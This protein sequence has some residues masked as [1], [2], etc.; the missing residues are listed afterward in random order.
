[1]I[2]D[3]SAQDRPLHAPRRRLP[4]RWLL[5]AGAVLA[6][7]A[8]TGVVARGW[9][10]GTGSVDGSRI[11]IAPVVRGTL[12]RDVSAEGR[13]TAS[14]SPTLYAVAGGT[15]DLKVIAGDRVERGQVLAVIDS[16]ELRS[17]LAQEQATAAALEA[18]VGRAALQVRQGSAEARKLVDQATIDHQ[19]AVREL[20]RIEKAHRLGALPEIDKL[21]AED[22][23]RK[24]EI[25]LAHARQDAALQGE[26]LGFDL[27]A[28]RLELER[29]RALADELARQVEALNL[30]SPVDG[31]VGQIMIPQFSNVAANAAVLSVVDLTA[32][33]LEI[34]VPESFARDLAIGMPAQIRSG[35]R[36]FEGKVRSVSPEVVNGEVVSRLQFVGEV[37]EG[38]RQ[39]QR[40]SARIVLDER[41]DVLMVERG[42]FL[43]AGGGTVAYV[44]RDGVAE[45][46]AIRTGASSLDAVEILEGLQEGERVVVSG[47]DAFAQAERI[48]IAGL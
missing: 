42:S 25:A 40:L 7:L 5:A 34:R 6:L 48:R 23:L 46:R 13:L 15:V 35:N 21:K 33:E 8:L 3:T 9:S 12:V 18:E 37:P 28:K 38:L 20:Q 1:M 45:R 47:T 22:E 27:S 41:P 4:L 24:A 11:R 32:F 44:M 19:A 36:Q 17:R 10:A 39:N 31:Q 2:P 26:G 43:E 30:R 29:Q 14:N 16:P